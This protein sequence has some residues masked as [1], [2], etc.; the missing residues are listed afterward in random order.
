M[1]SPDAYVR[2]SG[3]DTDFWFA[4]GGPAGLEAH[5]WNTRLVPVY[6]L[7]IVFLF[8]HL[9]GGLRVVL[10]KHWLRHGWLMPA[11]WITGALVGFVCRAAAGA[12][13]V[14]LIFKRR[15]VRSRS[16]SVRKSWR[17]G[18]LP[19]SEVSYRLRWGRVTL[20]PKGGIRL[21]FGETT[22]AAYLVQDDSRPMP[23]GRPCLARW[24]LGPGFQP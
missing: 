22:F 14:G 3:I 10:R 1:C 9:A 24:W 6:E 11:A 2:A 15:R 7:A 19:E 16:S 5:E 17:K 20:T 21:R 23:R 4:S 13:P 12:R 18:V 8:V